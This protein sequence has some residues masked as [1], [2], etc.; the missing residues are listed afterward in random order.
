MRTRK[1]NSHFRI[2]SCHFSQKITEASARDVSLLGLEQ[3]VKAGGAGEG[4]NK[5][6]F[7]NQNG[8]RINNKE[9]REKLLH[10][11]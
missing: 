10:E 5:M 6:R 2:Y 8:D 7:V 9:R 1:S 4:K 11:K 3:V